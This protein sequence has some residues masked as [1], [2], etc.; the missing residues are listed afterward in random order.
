MKRRPY[1]EAEVETIKKMTDDGAGPTAIGRVIG[2]TTASVANKINQMLTPK[3]A[4]TVAP[5]KVAVEAKR[6]A[7]R[8]RLPRYIFRKR[9]KPNPSARQEALVELAARDA[10]EAA[11]N[12]R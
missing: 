10:G 5:T 2:R 1:T 9:R 8:T 3:I 7:A 11:K 12:A 4:R 6:V